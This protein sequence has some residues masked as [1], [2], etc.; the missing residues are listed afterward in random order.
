[1]CGIANGDSACWC[2]NLPNII[3]LDA[4]G[5]GA[6]SAAGCYCPDCLKR[7]IARKMTIINL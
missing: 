7:E 4:A 6:G 3:E 2:F 1:M 5:G